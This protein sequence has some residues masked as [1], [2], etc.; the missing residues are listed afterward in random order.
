MSCFT[1]SKDSGE[2]AVY[3]IIQFPFYEHTKGKIP[4]SSKS[5]NNYAFT[6][7]L[8]CIILLNICYA[9]VLISFLIVGKLRVTIVIHN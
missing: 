3:Y 8:N 9:H 2:D 1:Q 7:K 6:K 4:S 5:K